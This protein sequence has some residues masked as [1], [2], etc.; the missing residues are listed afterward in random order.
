MRKLAG[1]AAIL[2]GIMMILTAVL[3]VTTPQTGNSILDHANHP[4]RFIAT[5]YLLAFG[6][7]LSIAMLPALQRILKARRSEWLTW[8]STIALIGFALTAINNFRQ[9]GLDASLADAYLKA[10]STVQE[11]MLINWAGL[12]ELSPQGW[13][14]Y[15]GVGSWILTVSLVALRKG[16][17]N[18]FLNL[19]GIATGTFYML[20]VIGNAFGIE[21]LLRVSLI[22]GGV[23]LAPIWFI[24]MGIRLMKEP[25]PSAKAARTAA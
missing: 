10:S 3:L 6:S 17:F 25:A 5:H 18:R 24:G 14:D 1:P 21:W 23:L 16:A 22:L 11:T 9:A 13:L 7:V 15:V 8:T 2:S 20:L 12:V 4:V 19:V